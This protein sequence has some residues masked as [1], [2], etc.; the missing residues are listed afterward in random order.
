VDILLTNYVN[1]K[2]L[3]INI[4]HWKNINGEKNEE[5]FDKYSKFIP[6]RFKT[7]LFQAL[8]IDMGYFY[9]ELN[10]DYYS[11]KD[12][13]LFILYRGDSGSIESVKNMNIPHSLS[14]NTS[15]LNG[16][17]SD[18]T[19]ATYNYFTP[20][21]N[22]KY[23]TIK[24]FHYNDGS[25]ESKLFFIPPIHPAGLLVSYGEFWHARS[26]IGSEWAPSESVPSKSASENYG[27]GTPAPSP[28]L[29][30]NV[31]YITGIAD[32][33]NIIPEFLFS[34]LNLDELDELYQNKIIK[35]NVRKVFIDSAYKKYLKYKMK[36][37]K[38]KERITKLK[39][40]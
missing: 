32:S 10:D 30:Y 1:Y 40:Y 39:T 2:L 28:S 31:R 4:N 21:C 35:G 9:N 37:Q 29:S 8:L 17:Y 22:K 23:Y 15:I 18:G 19:A 6:S 5:I 11:N 14:F 20:T 27:W 36:Y 26:K 12:K 16:I 38:L 25:D 24:K 33:L 34:S 7:I 13:S 3:D